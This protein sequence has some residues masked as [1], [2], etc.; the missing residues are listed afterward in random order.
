MTTTFSPDARLAAALADNYL[1]FQ[2]LA[3]TRD[4]QGLTPEE[5]A[6]RLGVDPEVVHYL[7]SH[8]SDPTLGELHDYLLAAEM[9]LSLAVRPWQR[10][11]GTVIHLSIPMHTQPMRRVRADVDV[12][13]SDLPPAAANWA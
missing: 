8:E 10:M 3:A 7:E 6:E 11:A 2:G 4:G 12:E 1:T 13:L 5:V 9:K